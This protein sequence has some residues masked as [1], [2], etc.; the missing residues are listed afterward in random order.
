MLVAL[1]NQRLF[2]YKLLKIRKITLTHKKNY[3]DDTFSRDYMGIRGK[4]QLLMRLQDGQVQ[5]MF[6]W[7]FIFWPSGCF[8]LFFAFRRA[9][10]LREI[11]NF[12]P[13]GRPLAVF[14]IFLAF[15][16]AEFFCPSGRPSAA[17]QDKK[18]QPFL[19][20]KISQIRPPAGPQAKNS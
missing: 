11:K 8:G 1:G 5:W 3:L 14:G 4:P 9:F 19:R 6:W 2:Y 20:P 12:W 16:K 18:I 17:P 15:G 7:L 13:S 10:V